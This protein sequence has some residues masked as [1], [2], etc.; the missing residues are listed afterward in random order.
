MS[1]SVFNPSRSEPG[2]MFEPERRE[3]QTDESIVN[4]FHLVLGCPGLELT[5]KPMPAALSDT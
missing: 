1:F 2:P 5:G 3:P 4:I